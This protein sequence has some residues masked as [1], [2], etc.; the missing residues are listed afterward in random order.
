MKNNYFFLIFFITVSINCISQTHTWTGNGDDYFWSD[1]Q[2][3]DQGTIP[4]VNGV[5]TVIIPVGVEVHSTS[6]IN[7]E[8]GEFTG[9]G[10][11]INNGIINL[12][13]SDE[14]L[15]S[16]IFSN[17][18]IWNTADINIYRANGILN[19]NPILLNEGAEIILSGNFANITTNN[20]GISFSSPI[21]GYL[22]LNG[23]FIKSGN[24]DVLI[25]I[26]MRICCYN[27]EVLEGL[28]LIE[29]KTFNQ[30]LSPDINVNENA[31]LIFSGENRFISGSTLDGIVNGYFEI[32]STALENPKIIGSFNLALE[33]D[34]YL[35][36][37]EFDGGGTLKNNTGTLIFTNNAEVV[38][39][40]VS[41]NSN[42]NF[43]IYPNSII[44]L[45]NQASLIN[46]SN[47]LIYGGSLV[48]ENKEEFNNGGTITFIDNS[49]FEITNTKFSN[50]GII[51]LEDGNL[52]LND[53]SSFTNQFLIEP[54]ELIGEVTGNGF[55]KF[56]TFNSQTIDNGGIFSP[57]PGT[58]DLSTENF[59]QT[60]EG[61]FNIE[62]ESLLSF[63]RII[64]TG[65]TYFEGGFEVSLI[66]YSPTIGD[67]F[68]VY[69]SDMSLNNCNPTSTVTAEYNNL[70]YI[71]DVICNDD[72]I[73]LK[74]GEILTI[75]NFEQ[76]EYSFYNYPNPVINETVFSFSSEEN[77]SQNHSIVIY[78]I[79]GQIVREININNGENLV[80]KRENLSS[81]VYFAKLKYSDRALATIKLVLK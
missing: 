38:L 43:E 18:T 53:T 45:K 21:P 57:G 40:N 16:K 56:P 26:E 15:T 47:L 64:N 80:F 49:A 39:N 17:I 30:I 79:F 71:F 72:H 31:S 66:D 25:D 63:D 20:V 35:Q 50:I 74:L 76:N 75:N 23:P 1:P 70:D 4:L 10:K 7:F 48:S 19:T 37:V 27:F 3:W 68:I 42:S 12:I 46:S 36:N 8:Y 13:N 67:E 65:T 62:I 52:L 9:G 78:N 14:V 60:S 58:T 33:G 41:I 61:I 51:N 77:L 59:T 28:L 22:E 55:F 34:I 32:K 6:L 29:P 5:G 11:F 81:G 73:T 2:N 44:T 69:Q 54:W 24:E